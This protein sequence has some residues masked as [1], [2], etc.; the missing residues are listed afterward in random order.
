MSADF[1]T[2]RWTLVLEARGTT[3]EA[4]RRALS[5]LCS[6]Y[7]RPLLLFVVRQ[8]TRGEEARDLTQAFFVHLFEHDFLRRVDRSAGKFRSF[9]LASLKHF[10][11]DERAKV[12]ALKR[13][14]GSISIPLVRTAGRGS[15]LQ[16]SGGQN[17]GP[18][19]TQAIREGPSY[20]GR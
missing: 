19:V 9:L 2:T 4:S 6:S 16:R 10:L 18:Q 3:S 13:G 1:R 14:G 20:G 5:E 17:G 12:A 11:A 8:G 7:W 15:G